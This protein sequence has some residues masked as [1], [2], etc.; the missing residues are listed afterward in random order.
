[1]KEDKGGNENIAKLQANQARDVANYEKGQLNKPAFDGMTDSMGEVRLRLAVIDNPEVQKGL[2]DV[3]NPVD[4]TNVINLNTG[5]VTLRWIGYPGGVIRPGGTDKGGTSGTYDNEPKPNQ[6]S[7]ST[8]DWTNWQIDSRREQVEISSPFI[9]SNDNNWCGFNYIPPVGSICVVGFKK[10][11]LPV[12]LGYINQ[13]YKVTAP[14]LRPGEMCMKGYGKNYI[15]W[16]DSDK[17]DIKAWSE[18]G[19]IDLDYVN[20]GLNKE[21]CAAATE[22]WVSLN[23]N[24]SRIDIEAF[25]G[26]NLSQ[27]TF[28]PTDITI[29]NSGSGGFTKQ[30]MNSTL[31]QIDTTTFR[32]NANLVDINS[33]KITQN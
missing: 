11:G 31:Y 24:D 6:V 8:R 33:A 29:V 20:A 26:G 17:I 7:P 12:I 18:A 4:P 23:A 28:T 15:H 9:W 16:R 14:V 1:M 3:T 27:A 30:Y 32:V 21:P 5:C 22:L 25:S 2:Y 19:D 13:H 10:H